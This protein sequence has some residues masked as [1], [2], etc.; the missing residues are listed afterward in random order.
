M[1]QPI[2]TNQIKAGD[3]IRVE[4]EQPTE[5]QATL[6]REFVAQCDRHSLDLWGPCRYYLLDR[7]KPTVVLPIE[8]TLG[9][10]TA[11]FGDRLIHT[12]GKGHGGTDV[13]DCGYVDSCA[14]T[15][16]TPATAVPT[17]ALDALRAEAARMNPFSYE[18]GAIRTF[19]KAVAAANGASA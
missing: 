6:A 1:K 9:W 5:I 17:A 13:T 19:L 16:F 11:N 8:P 10:A 14:I 15:A 18:A 2:D 4:W 12:A 3:L 7:P